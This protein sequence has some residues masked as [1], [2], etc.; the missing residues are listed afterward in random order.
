MIADEIERVA[1]GSSEG[2]VRALETLQG[3]F[4]ILEP[5]PYIWKLFFDDSA[6]APGRSPRRSAAT[7][8]ASPKP[9]IKVSPF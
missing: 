8:S 1:A 2:L 6:L 4:T 5:Q 3:I 9:P 7:A